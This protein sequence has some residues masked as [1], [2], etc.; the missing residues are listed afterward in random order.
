[1][2]KTPK[3]NDVE[4]NR[5]MYG[6]K[7]FLERQ[8]ELRLAAEELNSYV[9]KLKTGHDRYEAIRRLTMSQLEDIYHRSIHGDDSFDTLIDGIVAHGYKSQVSSN[10]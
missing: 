2:A 5:A 8:E 6:E 3:E 1:M 7:L 10:P 9:V 4:D